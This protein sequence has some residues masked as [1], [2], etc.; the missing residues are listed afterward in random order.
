MTD[1]TAA[2]RIDV[3]FSAQDIA[4][5][6]DALAA[7]IEATKPEPLLVVALLTGSFIFAADLIRGLERVGLHPEIDFISLSSYKSGTQSQGHIEILR[8]SA[9]DMAG[10]NVLI[11]D[12]ILDTGRTLAFARE[13]VASRGAA[14]VMTCVLL[15]KRARRTTQINADF[16]AFDCPDTFVVGYG[17]DFAHRHRELPFVGRIVT[18]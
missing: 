15:D 16:R 17:M 8:D 7:E 6:I 14:R 9:V 10:R 3:L 12:D 5:R 18:P 11:I 4:R 13:A 2:I 1:P